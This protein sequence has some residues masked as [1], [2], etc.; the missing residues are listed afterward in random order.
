MSGGHIDPAFWRGRRVLVTGHTGFKGAWLTLWLSRMGAHVSG[1]ALPPATA[2]D[3]FVQAR[4]ADG[5]QDSEML[6]IRDAV[7][8]QAFVRHAAPEIVFHLA[9]QPLVRASYADPVGTFATNV[10]G[11]A[12][13]LDAVRTTPGVRAVV[14]VT[15]DKCYESREWVWGY[16]EVDALGGCDPYSS[17]KAC[18]ELVAASYRQSFFTRASAAVGVATARSGNVV[19]GGDGGADRLV[20]DCLRA[21]AA[22]EAVCIRSPTAVRPWQHVLDALRGYLLLAAR[23]WNDP[24]TDAEAWNFG[25]DERD[26][27]TVEWMVRHLCARR[28]NGAAYTVA[29]VT[30]LHETTILRLDCAKARARLDW[31]PWGSVERALGDAAAWDA[32]LRQGGD[33]R[34]VSLTQLETYLSWGGAA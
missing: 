26:T 33:L 7:R 21:L 13:V 34:A 17:S 29:P 27:R 24:V 2:A 4:I 23:L 18:A 30:Q 5:L 1:C 3:V 10:L 16:R 22:G 25:P 28:G 9:A 15:T 14:V 8:V 6:D 32:A 19:G 11:T 20:P 12:H 31:W